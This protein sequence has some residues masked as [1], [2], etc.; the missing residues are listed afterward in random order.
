VPLPAEAYKLAQENFNKV[1]LG[2]AFGGV[3]EVGITV[4]ELLKREGKL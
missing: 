2:S 1:K 3:P 4:E